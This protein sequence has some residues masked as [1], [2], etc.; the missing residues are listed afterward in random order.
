LVE[1]FYH[2]YNPTDPTGTAPLSESNI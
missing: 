2:I 1:L